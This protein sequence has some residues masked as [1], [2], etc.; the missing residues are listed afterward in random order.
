MSQQQGKVSREIRGSLFLIGLDRAAKRN[1]FDSHMI[2]DL[3]L[4]LTEYEDDPEL[5]CAVIFA[6][7]DHFT[8][9]LDLVE[10]QP[11]LQTGVFDFESGQINPWG[12]TSRPR[13]KP[14]IVAVQGICYT[15]GIELMLNADMVIA[16]DNCQF[17]QMEVQRGILPFGG[18]TV[19]FVQAA[20]WSK[21]MRYLLTGDPFDATTALDL[22]LITEI[23]TDAPLQR[24]IELAEHI[25]QAAPLAVQATLASAKE[26]TEQGTETAFAHLQQHLTP[27]LKTQDVQEGVMAMLQRRAPEF[28][29]R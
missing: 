10:L 17:A 1:A 29:G 20:G 21:A 13:K 22:N 6:H 16:Q 18:A 26:A 27:L 4:A 7:G 14:V 9:G 15:A 25:V 28:K 23:T 2:Y 3:S 12:T 19:R 8:A 24:A 11:K 5:R